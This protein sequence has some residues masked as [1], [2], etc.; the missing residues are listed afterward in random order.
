MQI[1][2]LQSNTDM[3]NDGAGDNGQQHIRKISAPTENNIF[4]IEKSPNNGV[5][6]GA[7]N[8]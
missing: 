7:N 8:K 6:S 1:V 4:G 2:M 3:L 5:P